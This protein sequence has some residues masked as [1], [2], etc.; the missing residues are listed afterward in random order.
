MWLQVEV[1]GFKD[2]SFLHELPLKATLHEFNYAISKVI[3]SRHFMFI[4]FKYLIDKE[5]YKISDKFHQE[6]YAIFQQTCDSN[7]MLKHKISLS[8]QLLY[9]EKNN[10]KQLIQ[11][12]LTN[13]QFIEISKEMDKI[14]KL[15]EEEKGKLILIKS[16]TCFN[17]KKNLNYLENEQKIQLRKVFQ[18]N[19]ETTKINIQVETVLETPQEIKFEQPLELLTETKKRKIRQSALNDNALLST[20]ENVEDNFFHIK[21]KKIERIGSRKLKIPDDLALKN[22]QLDVISK[23]NL[24]INKLKDDRLQRMILEVDSAQERDKVLDYF[25]ETEKDFLLFCEEL[26]FLMGRRTN[27]DLEEVHQA[28]KQEEERLKNNNL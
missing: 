17:G 9:E 16:L 7:Y 18:L 15:K 12:Y 8:T 14:E 28:F 1:N 10:L 21:K 26:L 20:N 2:C 13:E 4:I 6:L 11:Q 5:L 19:N 27:Q 3:K 22:E 25:V 24:L 23:S